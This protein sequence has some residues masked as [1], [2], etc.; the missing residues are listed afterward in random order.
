[1][2]IVLGW[3]DD[4]EMIY[5]ISITQVLFFLKIFIHLFNSLVRPS[6]SAHILT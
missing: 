2:L 1:M 5:T 4:R 6:S 3:N